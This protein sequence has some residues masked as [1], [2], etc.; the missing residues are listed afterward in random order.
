MQSW[1]HRLPLGLCPSADTQHSEQCPC[2]TGV[3]NYSDVQLLACMV[4]SW[5]RPVELAVNPLYL[6]Q[7]EACLEFGS[8]HSLAHLDK[9]VKCSS[10]TK[11]SLRAEAAMTGFLKEGKSH[12][13]IPYSALQ[14][15]GVALYSCSE[16]SHCDCHGRSE[17]V[18]AVELEFVSA[19]ADRC[20]RS[21]GERSLFFG[22]RPYQWSL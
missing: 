6:W 11:P 18:T 12:T 8:L 17:G 14:C 21:A 20:L 19:S 5:M 10:I 13:N 1:L 22:S 3:G 16:R 4:P 2:Q 9:P 15:S 7:G